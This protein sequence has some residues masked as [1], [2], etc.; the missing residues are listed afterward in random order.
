MVK[1]YLACDIIVFIWIQYIFNFRYL[2]ILNRDCLCTYCNFKSTA[3]I[4]RK[5]GTP[6]HPPPLGRIAYYSSLSSSVSNSLLYLLS[7]NQ[8]NSGFIKVWA[9]LAYVFDLLHAKVKFICCTDVPSESWYTLWNYLK[10]QIKFCNI[11]DEVM[12]LCITGYAC[13]RPSYRDMPSYW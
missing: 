3:C 9:I 7:L 6:S 5:L 8:T 1:L 2:K 13:S 11:I 10:I 4:T 12:L